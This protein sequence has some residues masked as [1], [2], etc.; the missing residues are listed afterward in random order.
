MTDDESLEQKTDT[1]E[2]EASLSVEVVDNNHQ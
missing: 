2:E 1:S